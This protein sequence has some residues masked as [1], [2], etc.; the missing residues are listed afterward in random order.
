VTWERERTLVAIS[1]SHSRLFFNFR[2]DEFVRHRDA[3]FRACD[4]HFYDQTFF[5]DSP[6]R[7]AAPRVLPANSIS[8]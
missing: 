1:D 5:K 3:A 8:T 7:R 4:E 6:I 2:E